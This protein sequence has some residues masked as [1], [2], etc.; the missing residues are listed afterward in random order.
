MSDLEYNIRKQLYYF[1]AVRVIDQAKSVESS[2]VF[3]KM[4]SMHNGINK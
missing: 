2:F 1:Y 4:Q 3:G